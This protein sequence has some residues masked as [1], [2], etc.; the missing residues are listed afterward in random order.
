MSHWPRAIY[1]EGLKLKRS[2]A[3]VLMVATP[4][5]IV[6]MYF[7]IGLR[8]GGDGW[9]WLMTNTLMLW[10]ALF[11]PLCI[12]TETALLADLEI[13][14]SQWKHLFALPISRA[15][16]Y[17]AKLVVALLL[18]VLSML[19][20][21][22]GLWSA[23]KGLG[24]FRPEMGFD[25]PFPWLRWLTYSAALVP[26]ACL[27]LSLH[28]WVSLRF[29]SFVPSVG[30]GFLGMA[31]AGL[32]VAQDA[33]PYFPWRLPLYLMGSLSTGVYEPNWIWAGALGGL[34]F[35]VIGCWEVTRR[36]VF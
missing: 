20:F 28:T 22:I 24:V 32:L 25:A 18:L 6:F 3:L 23:G 4:I 36:D 35:A 19:V 14:G 10:T 1:A 16:L 29:R 12:A 17:T 26:S 31:I 27:L 5:T 13:R 33:W 15:A 2:P 11:L 8:S 7:C 34:L 21:G 30:S 9:S